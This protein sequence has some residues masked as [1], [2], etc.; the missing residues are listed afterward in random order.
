MPAACKQW[1]AFKRSSE[2]ELH[3]KTNIRSIAGNW[4]K[5]H[6]LDKHTISSEFLG[7]DDNGN[8]RFDTKRSEV[9]EALYQLK[10]RGD[11][12][13]A[14]LLAAAIATEVVPLLGEF[15]MIIP[16]PASKP[17]SW[18]PVTEVARELGKLT[19]KPVI[20]NLLVRKAQGQQLKDLATKEE[21]MAA[22][23]DAFT[24]EEVITNDGH[25]NA[26]L[27]DDLFGTGASM[28]GATDALKRYNKVGGVY[29]AA[30]TW[31]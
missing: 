29:L 8:P 24:V 31:K 13:K 19:G 6:V 3:V 28:E 18:Q 2:R 30:L 21:K 11:K 23:K 17:R 12:S 25:W 5:G 9:G 15:G 14:P 26:L 16:M 10:Y 7:Y 20:E 4:D 1:I 22:L 27:L